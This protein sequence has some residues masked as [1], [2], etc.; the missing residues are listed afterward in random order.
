MNLTVGAVRC[1]PLAAAL[2]SDDEVLATTPEW[3]G[4]GLGCVTY[5]ARGARLVVD[6]GAAS[7][8]SVAVLAMLLDAVDAAARHAGGER[9]A[10][11]QVLA[12]SLRVLAGRDRG[13]RGDINGAVELLRAAAA[14]RTA[15]RLEL[16]D[17]R[18]FDVDDPAVVALL[19]VQ[20]V[21]NAER[22]DHAV[23][24]RVDAADGVLRLRWAGR[25][26]SSPSTSRQRGERDRWGLG[27]ARIAADSIGAVVGAPLP[28][29]DGEVEAAIDL[30]VRR[31][32]LPLAAARDG[33]VRAATAPWDEETG[34][35]PGTAIAV[36]SRLG[37]LCAAAATAPGTIATDAGWRARRAGEDTW[38]AIPPD[39]VSERIADVLDGLVHERALWDGVPLRARIPVAALAALAGATCGRPLPRVTAM[40][41][42]AA[43]PALA[44]ATGYAGEVPEVTGVGAV[45][46]QVAVYLATELGGSLIARDDGIVLRL[47]VT[48]RSDVRLATLD[49]VDGVVRLS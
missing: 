36:G 3:R 17:V 12:A 25:H 22:H 43:S 31:L 23:A 38:L 10:R 2:L 14:A 7:V 33:R 35:T 32:A 28:A 21:A 8:H 41:W 46:P 18:A 26:G 16:G 42:N 4:P 48:R 45:D 44:A 9:A 6:T 13:A 34:V 29:G 20:L 37:M 30:G 40:S 49:V 19:A 1:L 11:V 15:V 47:P 5:V 39:G 27:C 24:V